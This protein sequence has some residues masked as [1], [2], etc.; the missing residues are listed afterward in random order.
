MTGRLLLLRGLAQRHLPSPACGSRVCAGL[1]AG[2]L[3]LGWGV[4]VVTLGTASAKWGGVG[5][6]LPW[7]LSL[8]KL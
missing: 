1:S 8:D 7:V 2:E 6:P 5:G 3:S 4:T